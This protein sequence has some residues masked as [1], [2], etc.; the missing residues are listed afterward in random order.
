MAAATI[1]VGGNQF[2]EI[3][4][5]APPSAHVI[6][7]DREALEVAIKLAA[8]FAPGASRRDAERLLP[9]EEV[10]AYSKSGL[11]GATVPKE[12]GGAGISNVTLAEFI[13]ILA[14]ADP[15]I[16]QITQN[17][18]YIIESIR[19]DGT[20]VQ[21][22]FFFDL[23]LQGVRFGN[24]FSE[25]G[26]KS[27]LDV[28]TRLSRNSRGYVVNGKKFYSTGALLAHWIPIVAVD[29]EERTVIA[30]VERSAE[31]LT[32]INDWSSFGQRAT[33]SGSTI[34]QNVQVE[35][36]NV[37]EHWRAFERATTIGPVAQII[38]AAIDVGIAIAALNDTVEFVR[39]QS[40]PWIDAN[41]EKATQDP[42]L[43][44]KLGET[45]IKVDA[46]EAILRRAGEYIDR[47]FIDNSEPVVAAAQIAVGEAKAIAE[48][49]AIFAAD[50][51]NELGGTRSTLAEFNL[52][53]HWR[54][55]RVHTLHDPGRWKYYAIGNYILNG[56]NPPKHP[57]F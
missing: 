18:L 20:E 24:A 47:A 25:I 23:A 53:R 9:V 51:V 15:S 56:V 21:K 12:Y 32:L 13:K 31:G 22:R 30:L 54:N 29:E 28:H 33:A 14:V 48:E 37:I 52:D 45:K 7:S 36:D 4:K 40:R 57:W 39:K 41:V 17:H 55:A 44:Y 2:V 8:Q 16:T 27:V 43:L 50:R 10:E 42:L 1:V 5:P 19:L 26:T 6:K 34:I 49:A 11:W 35:P 46:A 3:P 38:Q